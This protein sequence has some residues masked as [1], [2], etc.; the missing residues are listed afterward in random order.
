MATLTQTV[1]YV[2]GS[3]PIRRVLLVNAATFAAHATNYW[4]FELRRYR[5][6]DAQGQV[7]ASFSTRTKAFTANKPAIL[8]DE[9][10]GF[11]LDDGDAL[12]V[13]VTSVGSPAAL[14]HPAFLVQFQRQ[15]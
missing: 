3:E 4:T 12:R 13:I 7:I 10:H 1:H 2:Q 9:E 5:A 8:F 14:S 15:T 11:K 6:D